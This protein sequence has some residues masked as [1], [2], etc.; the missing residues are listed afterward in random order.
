MALSD[1]G[2]KKQ[3]AKLLHLDSSSTKVYTKEDYDRKS[4]KCE[5]WFDEL[6]ACVQKHG[7]NDNHCQA[8]VKPKYDQC[9]IK[10]DQI[11]T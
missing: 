2:L 5:H 6:H 4:A 11:K 1:I 7:W 3:I 8:V 9:I 10:R